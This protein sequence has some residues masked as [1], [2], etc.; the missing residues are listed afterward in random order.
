M[1]TFKIQKTDMLQTIAEYSDW[2]DY[3]DIESPKKIEFSLNIDNLEMGNNDGSVLIVTFERSING[4]FIGGFPVEAVGL[5]DNGEI[6]KWLQTFSITEGDIDG[7][8]N[9]VLLGSEGR[10]HYSLS[11]SGTTIPSK[12]TFSAAVLVK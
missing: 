5:D 12:A 6:T 9:K 7:N 4:V 10:F 3:S 2:F 8:G 1:K 11:Q